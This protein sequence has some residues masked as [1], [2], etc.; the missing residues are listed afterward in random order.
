MR[1]IDIRPLREFAHRR[2]PESVMN[3]FPVNLDYDVVRGGLP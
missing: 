3:H 1:K 2:N